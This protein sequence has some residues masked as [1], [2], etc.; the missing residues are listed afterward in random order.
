M[1]EVNWKGKC[2]KN[3]PYFVFHSI[4]SLVKGSLVTNADMWHTGTIAL[5]VCVLVSLYE[6]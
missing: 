4:D 3:R 1:A 5:H 6:M 2:C